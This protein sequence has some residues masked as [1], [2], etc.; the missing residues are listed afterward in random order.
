MACKANGF[1][2][3]RRARPQ[4]RKSLV[5]TGLGNLAWVEVNR[6]ARMGS[7]IEMVASCCSP[8][9]WRFVLGGQANVWGFMEGEKMGS[10]LV[11]VLYKLTGVRGARGLHLG[12]PG[13]K[14]LGVL[15]VLQ[16]AYP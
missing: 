3:H 7:S 6:C 4:I 1:L 14:Q 9:S 8:G 5:F 11:A 12:T 13:I 10:R 2:F 15:L 16:Q